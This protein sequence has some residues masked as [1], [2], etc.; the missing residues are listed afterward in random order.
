M[1][2]PGRRSLALALLLAALTF[3]VFSP[4]V[5]NGFI[6]FDDDKYI[7][8]NP[9]VLRG[10]TV[11][12][13]LW[14]LTSLEHANWHPLTW[15]SHM[16][17]FRLFGLWAGGHH[18]VSA[19]IHA[20]N[21]ALLF[22]VLRAMTGA[23]WRSAL[24]AA[25]FGF[26]PLRVESVAWA[27]ER[28]DV[29]AVLFG[30]LALGAY[31][32]HARRRTAGS[33]AAALGLYACALMSKAM[34][35]TFPAI[36][37]LLDLWP[38]DRWSRARGAP[39]LPGRRLLLEKI[40]FLALAV[41][42]SAV[43]FY[44]QDTGG[45]VSYFIPL[46]QRLENAFCSYG[47]YLAKMLWPTKLAVFYPYFWAEVPWWKPPLFAVSVAALTA[48]AVNF[49]RRRPVWFVG[50]AWYLGT[51]LPVIGVVQ[52]GSQA[53]ADRYT[54]IPQIGVLLAIVWGLMDA[55]AGRPRFRMATLVATPVVLAALAAATWAQAGIWRTSLTLF[56]HAIQVTENNYIAFANL[57]RALVNEGRWAEG[58]EYISRSF[59][60]APA[61]RGDL[62]ES[63]GDYYAGIGLKREA[64][65]QY[66]KALALS[67]KRQVQA[68]LL[69]LGDLSNAPVSAPPPDPHQGMALSGDF[70]R[71]NQLVSAGRREEA[72]AA[73]REAIRA[74][75]RNAEAWHNLGCVLG[76]LGRLDEATAAFEETLRLDPDHPN[77]RKNLE[78]IPG[79]R[80]R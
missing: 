9:Q 5:Q 63:T 71:G 50:W 61:F 70:A 34:L 49:L 42:A 78:L 64:A 43:T 53:M 33:Y 80:G 77:A 72:A 68:K 2:S 11:T 59:S 67:P 27:S 6:N 40:P 73:Y 32:S 38:L 60:A 54:Y 4:V 57:G 24:V 48:V 47:D 18:A 36:L 46:R 26:H 22:L 37:L 13:A 1:I 17:D 62:F 52:V 44:A 69:A 66:R 3:A 41:A 74:D 19:L 51:L 35:V 58:N 7:S 45:A 23:L 75:P 25:V 76:E 30:L 56:S 31:L 79:R 28:K 14:A 29:L 21:V 16:L 39:F 10:L 15:L 8:E 55:T 65:E 12:T 20:A